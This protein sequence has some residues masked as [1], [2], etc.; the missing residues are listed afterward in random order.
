MTPNHDP[1]LRVEALLSVQRGML[2]NVTPGLRVATLDL[3]D[4]IHIRFVYAETIDDEIRDLVDDV[5]TEMMADV[6]DDVRVMSTVE[7]IP[8]G[9][10]PLSSSEIPV[11][12]RHE[13]PG[14][15]RS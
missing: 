2:G 3:T 5:E 14:W 13:F 11:F 1:T 7:S 10:I 6:P 9:P 12:H 4:G 8:E 15:V